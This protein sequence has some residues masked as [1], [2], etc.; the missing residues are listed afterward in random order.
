MVKVFGVDC[1][2]GFVCEIIKIFEI[3]KKMIL[4]ELVEFI[5]NDYY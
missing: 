2:V 1:F 5:V 4:G 3:I